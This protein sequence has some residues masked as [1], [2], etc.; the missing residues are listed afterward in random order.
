M[1]DLLDQA[2]ELFNAGLK[3]AE[4]SNHETALESFKK[5][6]TIIKDASLTA[7]DLTHTLISNAFYSYQAI[8]TAQSESLP[9]MHKAIEEMK[10]V[11]P[12]N[13]PTAM[14]ALVA[15]YNS[16]AQAYLRSN[17]HELALKNFIEALKVM[18]NQGLASTHQYAPAIISEIEKTCEALHAKA[19]ESYKSSD[20]QAAL[21]TSTLILDAMNYTSPEHSQISAYLTYKGINYLYLG[22]FKEALE[23]LKT[24]SGI[25]NP[26]DAIHIQAM[27]DYCNI[28]I[29]AAEATEPSTGQLKDLFGQVEALEEQSDALLSQ[30]ES[31]CQSIGYDDLENCKIAIMGENP[32]E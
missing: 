23:H 16:I 11:F 14:S 7:E 5:A 24:S 8:T 31:I 3:E 27:I 2:T 21:D 32:G 19:K 6:L 17:Q 29:Q 25:A 15:S 22:K 4:N 9:Y 28:K 26:Q 30:A 20:F 18:K 12:I 1:S 13:H 10:E